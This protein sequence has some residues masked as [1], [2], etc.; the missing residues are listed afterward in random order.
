M[1]L[2][3]LLYVIVILLLIGTGLH[4]LQGTRINGTIKTLIYIFVFFAVAIW[5]VTKVLPAA[6]LGG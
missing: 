2:E 3:T 6:G 5:I 1:S 4:F